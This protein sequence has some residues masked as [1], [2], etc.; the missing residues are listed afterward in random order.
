M[1]ASS[2]TGTSSQNGQKK[3]PKSSHMAAQSAQNATHRARRSRLPE[4]RFLGIAITP[5]ITTLRCPAT[6]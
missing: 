1:I 4:A 5:V 6:T 3:T 2:D